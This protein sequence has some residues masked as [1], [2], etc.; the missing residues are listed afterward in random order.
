MHSY[1]SL[2]FVKL[3]KKY[4]WGNKDSSCPQELELN[5]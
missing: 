5:L 4:K 2:K 3:L 1:K